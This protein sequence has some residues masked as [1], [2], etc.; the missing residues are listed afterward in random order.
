M[1]VLDI[2]QDAGVGAAAD[3]RRIGL[4]ACALLGAGGDEGRLELL[5]RQAWPGCISR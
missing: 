2:V 5:L 1:G 4:E 3:D